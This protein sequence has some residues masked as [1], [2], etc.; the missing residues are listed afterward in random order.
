MKSHRGLILLMVISIWGCSGAND[1]A[2]VLDSSGKHP[3]GWV[4]AANGGSHPAAHLSAPGKCTECHGNDLKGGISKVSCFSADRNGMTCHAQGPSGHAAGW[5]LGSAH[6]AHAKS[7][8]IGADGL[9]FCTNCH[10][11][12]YRGA[13]DIRK[14]CLRCHITAPH[15]VAANWRSAGAVTHTDTVQSNAPACVGCHNSATPN[16]AAPSSSL[17]ANSPAGSFKGGSPDCFSASMCHGD[18]RKTVDCNACHSIATTSPFKSLA[19]ATSTSDS[20]VGAHVKHLS[21]FVQVPAYSSNIACSECHDV[22]GSPITSGTHRNGTNDIIFGTLANIG[23]LTPTYTAATGICANTYCHGTTL[24]GGGSNKSP[25]WNQANYLAGGCSTCHGFP[26]TTVRNGAAAHS[27]SGA[28][29][30]CHSHVN[31]SNNGFSDASKHINGIVESTDGHNFP[32]QGSVHMN[33]AGTTPWSTCV[34]CHSNTPGGT[35]PVAAGVAPNCTGCHIN[36]LRVPVGTSSCWDCHGSSA[37]N[38]RPNGTTFPNRNGEH[39]KHNAIMAN[40]DYCHFGG[41]TGTITHGNSNRIAK[42][43]KD[44]KIAKNPVRY[45]GA[46][47]ITIIQDAGTGVVTCNGSCHIG[48][49]T[50]V[51]GNETWL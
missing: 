47:T 14:D 22:P 6:G 15:P 10:G 36:G 24:T 2:I 17:F 11:T 16:L 34:A 44:V 42:G 3:G 7:A 48:V 38:G 26:P 30:G 37:T 28:C 50:E 27:A 32:L 25:I 35:Y 5:G 1:S 4:V 43:V 29:A 9:A 33:A 40:C 23:P 39:A 19:G 49:K 21:A 46:D 45:T 41:G 13:G 31:S 8:A 12:D 51:H 18:V 20:K